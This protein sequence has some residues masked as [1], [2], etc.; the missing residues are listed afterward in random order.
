MKLRHIAAGIAV[1]SA[2]TAAHYHDS[3]RIE[4]Q[5]PSPAELVSSAQ[6]F[7]QRAAELLTACQEAEQAAGEVLSEPDSTQPIAAD[8]YYR[9]RMQWDDPASQVGAYADYDVA[10]RCCPAGYTVFSPDGIPLC[11]PEE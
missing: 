4:L 11:T 7:A 8:N 2:L 5:M 1:L 10:V 3:I 6:Q 9:I